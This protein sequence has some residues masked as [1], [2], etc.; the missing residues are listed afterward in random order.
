[1]GIYLSSPDTRKHSVDGH[2]N[3]VAYGASS[4]QGWRLNMEDAHISEAIFTPNSS[5]FA[6]FDGHGGCEVAKYCAKYFGDELK[7]NKKFS[8]E[9]NIEEAL[10]ETFL[11]MDEMLVTPEGMA[12]VKTLKNDNDGSDSFA[13]C[14]ANVILILKGVVWCANSGDS[15]TILW[16]NKKV[17]ALSEDHKPDNEIEK[18]RISKAGGFII[19]GRVNGN[20]NLS[21]ALGDLEYKK[22]PAL[23]PAEQLISAM[24]DVSKRVLKP[25]DTFLVMGCDGIWEILSMEEICQ[26]AEHGLT[27]A[28]KITEVAEEILDKGL[29]TDTSQGIGCDNM[30]AI[31]IKLHQKN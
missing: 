30:S 19:E 23:K 12:E 4:M 16:S 28:S 7:K 14:T 10:K 6:V 18:A 22:N 9:S 15:R 25:E 24:P 26:V 21:R 3:G 27:K 2:G 5:L 1:M 20:L 29:A 11:K 31:V 17:I 8:T 13:G